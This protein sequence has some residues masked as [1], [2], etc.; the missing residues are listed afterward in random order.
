MK[1]PIHADGVDKKRILRKFILRSSYYGEWRSKGA[2]AAKGITNY[3]L[4]GRIGWLTKKKKS[5][6][7]KCNKLG[8]VS[9]D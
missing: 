4:S 7:K 3:E 9:T 6:R 5:K 1:P 8:M 2:K